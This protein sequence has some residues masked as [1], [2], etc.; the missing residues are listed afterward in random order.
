MRAFGTG[1][2]RADRLRPGQATRLPTATC[3]AGRPYLV[4]IERRPTEV[5]RDSSNEL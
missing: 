3:P 4:L 1:F 5:A 2:P